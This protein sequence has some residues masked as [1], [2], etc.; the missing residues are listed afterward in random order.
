ME[1]SMENDYSEFLKNNRIKVNKYLNSILWLFAL[2]GPAIAIGVKCGIFDDISL[3]TCIGI[4]T[5]VIILSGIHLLLVKKIPSSIATGVFAL[6][7]LD[8]L[9]VYMSYSHVSIYLT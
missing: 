6:T 1:N 4:S 5:V 9:L 7:A 8:L 2:T 3:T